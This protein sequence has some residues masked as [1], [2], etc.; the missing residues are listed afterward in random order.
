MAAAGAMAIALAWTS[1]A[2]AQYDSY[3]QG[4]GQDPGYGTGAA[5]AQAPA[6]YGTESSYE[7]GDTWSRVGWGALTAVSNLAYVPAK[8]VYA[9]LGGLTG[10][11][12]LGLTGGDMSTAQQI[13]EPSLG[14]DYFLTPGQ[15][16]GEKGVSFAGAAGLTQPV[17]AVPPPG[18]APPP[19][20]PGTSQYGG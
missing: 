11:L 12:A 9:G 13:W 15:I 17:P 19:I 8:L 18:D 16:Q 6:A 5:P 2:Q 4:Y 10:G 7:G 3:Y 1:G 20:D 14:G